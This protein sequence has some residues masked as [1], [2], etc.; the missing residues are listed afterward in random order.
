MARKPHALAPQQQGRIDGLCALYATLNGCKHLFE[1]AQRSDERLF[2]HLCETAVPDLFPKIMYEGTDTK[3][4]RR[5]LAGAADWARAT[6]HRELAWSAPAWRRS[7]R[8]ARDYFAFLRATLERL[9]EGERAVFVVGLATPLDHW[10]VFTG[11]TAS[12]ALLFDS[13]GLDKS[14]PIDAF[15]LSAKQ[16]GEGPGKK[17]QIDYHQ[18][19]MMRVAAK[20]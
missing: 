7:F 17:I 19:F 15:T 12:D 1:H 3:G 8:T 14:M 5:L 16:A 11:A 13:W 4:V 20:R 18:T 2:K 9:E 10:T 6:H